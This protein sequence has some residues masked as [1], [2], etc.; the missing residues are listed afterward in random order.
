MCNMDEGRVSAAVRRAGSTRLRLH[1]STSRADRPTAITS[2]VVTVINLSLATDFDVLQNAQ[3]IGNH[4]GH[5]VV[6][7][8][9]V[10][11]DRFVVDT[12]ESD[13]EPRL[14]FIGNPS[15]M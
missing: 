10:G 2:M 5:R 4:N 13:V 9:Q 3:R 7:A 11:N 14:D 12:H 6:G 15:L 1:A 8:D